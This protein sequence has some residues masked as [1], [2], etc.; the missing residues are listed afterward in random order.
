MVKRKPQAKKAG[1][2]AAGPELVSITGIAAG[3]ATLAKFIFV[4]MLIGIGIILLLA[5]TGLAIIF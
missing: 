3:A 4:V 2:R 5:F 1:A